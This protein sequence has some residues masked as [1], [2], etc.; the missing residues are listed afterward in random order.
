MNNR[1]T[2]VELKLEGVYRKVNVYNVWF[3]VDGERIRCYEKFHAIDELDVFKQ[4]ITFINYTF[5]ERES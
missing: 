3:R 1:I 2:D 4:L 5:P